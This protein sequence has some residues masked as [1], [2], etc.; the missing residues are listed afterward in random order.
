MLTFFRRIRKGLLG[1]GATSKYLLYAVGEIA[2]VVTG[3]LIA[4]Q[5]NNWNENRKAA[6]F[7]LQLITEIHTAIL[8]DI[9][10]VER[11]VENNSF[12]AK[13]CQI[14]LDHFSNRFEY[15][16]SLDFHFG[17]SLSWWKVILDYNAYE[18]AKNYGLH[19]FR[20]DS[21]RLM[22]ADVYEFR[23]SW[24]NTMET[25]QHDYH[26]NIVTPLM[27]DLFETST[28]FEVLKP[29]EF[30][31]LRKNKRYL[32]V[33]KSSLINRKTEVQFQADI[34]ERLMSLKRL[35]Q[36]EI[37]TLQNSI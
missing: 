3:I 8:N 34:L 4:L 19:M 12:S 31:R 26:F 33:L 13:S 36:E 23:Q 14:I 18:T 1:E 25:R 2:L 20:S 24:I 16:D 22:L 10:H 29:I 37:E 9:K 30:D 17:Q 7:E 28:V 5:I 35:L 32:N 21:I 27:T 6:K 15:S 11:C